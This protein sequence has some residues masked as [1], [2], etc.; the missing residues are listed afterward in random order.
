[1]HPRTIGILV[2]SILL[3][4]LVMRVVIYQTGLLPVSEELILK[5][6]T[7]LTVGYTLAGVP[8][9]VT[10]NQPE[11][12]ADL[13]A[14]LDL[15]RA[16]ESKVEMPAFAGPGGMPGVGASVMFHFPDGTSRVMYFNGANWLG[17][18]EVNPRFYERLRAHISRI[19][20]R[21]VHILQENLWDA[22]PPLRAP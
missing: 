17:G 8:K 16:N 13:F 7:A 15:Y 3:L 14:V 1:M 21:P 19:E 22:N 10:I 11:Q 6:A 9:S 18:S 5:Q 4:A 12:L 20:G 2:G